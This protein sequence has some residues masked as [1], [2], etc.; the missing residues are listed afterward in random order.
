MSSTDLSIVLLDVQI[1]IAEDEIEY[2]APV[3]A[4][5]M[6]ECCMPEALDWDRF[7]K[8]VKERKSSAEDVF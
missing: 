3:N 1:V 2:L 6:A 7:V 4:D 8:I 5:F